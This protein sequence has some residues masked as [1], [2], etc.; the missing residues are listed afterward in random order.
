MRHVGLGVGR[1]D[2]ARAGELRRLLD[3][4]GRV[5]AR[6]RLDHVEDFC[7][8]GQFRPRRPFRALDQ[9]IAR[10]DRLLLARGD[11][12]QE[13]AVAY[14]RDHARH[15]LHA[16]LVEAFE[17][18]AIARRPHHPAMH[19]AGQANVLHIDRP[20]RDLGRDVEA[21][22]R[23]ADDRVACRILRRDFGSRLALEI[24]L[25]SQIAVADLAAVGARDRAV[26]DLERVGRRVELLGR[27]AEQDRAHF[28]RRHAQRGAAV[29]DRL[30]AGGLAFVRRPAGVA[31]HHRDLVQRQIEL[32]GRDLAQRRENAL[33]EFDLA[34]VHGRGAVRI[35]AD[36]GIEHPVGLQAAGERRRLLGENAMRIERERDDDGAEA[37]GELAAIESG[38]VHGQVLPL[39]CAARKTARTMRLCVPQRQRLPASPARTSCSVGF[40]LRSSNSFADMIMPLMQ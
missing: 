25:R 6:Q 24:G 22:N 32:F 4:D 1:L 21:R 5:L 39:A 30:A 9:R 20:A 7:R 26:G 3:A 29:L 31:G 23:F 34:G 17:P 33:A 13:R 15:G 16:G 38:T 36:P 40:G 8:I 27:K 37:C 11:D 2:D 10:L 28:G 35:D 18:G 14:H 12:T 19:H